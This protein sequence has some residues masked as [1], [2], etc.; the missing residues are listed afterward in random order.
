MRKIDHIGLA[1]Q[2]LQTSAETYRK[3]GFTFLGEETVGEQKVRVAFFECGESR[4]ELL[5]PTAPD[6]PIAKFLKKRGPGI[7]HLCVQVDDLDATL[8]AYKEKG[9]ALIHETPVQ[10]AHNSRVAFIHPKSTG[11]VLMELQERSR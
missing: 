2:D 7:H 4:I 11:G 10:G 3:L 6:S 8:A 5:E 9:I 1:V